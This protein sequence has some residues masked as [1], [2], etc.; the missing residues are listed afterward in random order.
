IEAALKLKPGDGSALMERGLL[1]RQLGDI[2]GAR[3]DFQAALRTGSA[4][5]AA[6]AQANLEELSP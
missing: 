2:G 3:R 6:E 1:R 5:I 4:A